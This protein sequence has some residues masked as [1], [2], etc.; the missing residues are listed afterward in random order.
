MTYVYLPMTGCFGAT[1]Y[2]CDWINL[3]HIECYNY[4][5]EPTCGTN[6][7]T[8]GN[9]WVKRQ[10]NDLWNYAEYCNVKVVVCFWA[11]C[12]EKNHYNN[13]ICNVQVC[14]LDSKLL[15]EQLF[16]SESDTKANG[17]TFPYQVILMQNQ[18]SPLYNVLYSMFILT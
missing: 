9:K 2:G 12:L 5:P 15:K 8:Y 14:H 18:H 13:R 3:P 10:T 11:F 6:L 16:F 17:Y 4:P 7:V 1:F